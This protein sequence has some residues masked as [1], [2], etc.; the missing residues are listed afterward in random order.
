MSRKTQVRK[1]SMRCCD[2][3]PELWY[4]QSYVDRKKHYQRWVTYRQP[5]IEQA[6][7]A[8]K[9]NGLDVIR[10]AG[11]AISQQALLSMRIT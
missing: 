3:L 8:R 11:H 6:E 9:R 2:M 5:M 1:D 4:L 10:N 7:I